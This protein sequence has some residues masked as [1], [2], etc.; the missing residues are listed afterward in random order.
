MESFQSVTAEKHIDVI[1][2]EKRK[3][4]TGIDTTAL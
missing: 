1:K 2:F 4:Y 3:Y